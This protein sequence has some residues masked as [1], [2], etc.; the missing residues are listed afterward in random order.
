MKLIQ[1]LIALSFISYSFT[2]SINTIYHLEKYRKFKY[3]PSR[4]S[5]TVIDPTDFKDTNY[6]YL[7]YKSN[8]ISILG[9][10]LTVYSLDKDLDLNTESSKVKGEPETR[11]EEETDYIYQISFII[12]KEDDHKLI[13]IENLVSDGDKM[14]LENKR[15][16]P[17]IS[18]IGLIIVLTILFG[19]ILVGLILLNY[20]RGESTRI[21][22]NRKNIKIMKNQNIEMDYED[23]N[24]IIKSKRNTNQIPAASNDS[25]DEDNDSNEPNI[26][27]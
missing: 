2:I 13:I 18:K 7:T 15:Y 17:L 19:A 26:I 22:T 1:F 20:I 9:K 14:E 4:V 23:N 21:N 27:N 25:T 24:I 11:N 12:Q 5:L 10:N 8:D 6:I 16:M 3:D